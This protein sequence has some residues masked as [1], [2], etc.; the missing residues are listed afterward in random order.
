MCA[1]NFFFSLS[2]SNSLDLSEE[3]I[4]IYSQ[5]FTPTGKEKEETK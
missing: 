4:L 1:F 3:K 5:I 2:L